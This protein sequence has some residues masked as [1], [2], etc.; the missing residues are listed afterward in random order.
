MKKS[1]LDMKERWKLVLGVLLLLS[2]VTSANAR[3]L[4]QQTPIQQTPMM[5][6]PSGKSITDSGL[7]AAGGYAAASTNVSVN[8]SVRPPSILARADYQKVYEQARALLTVGETFRQTELQLPPSCTTP[9]ECKLNYQNFNNGQLFFGF[10]SNYDEIDIRGYC[11]GDTPATWPIADTQIRG[12]LVRAREMYGFLALAEPA[13]VEVMVGGQ[14]ANVREIGRSGVLSAT[15]EIANIHMIF[16]NEFMVDAIDY[17][18]G[19]NDPRADQII[20]E[21]M[22]QLAMARQQFEQAVAVLTHAFNADFGGPNGGYIG[23][24]FGEREFDL[25]GI[26]SERMVLAISETAD[27][28]RQLGRDEEALTLYSEAFAN[29]YVQAMALATSADEQSENFLANGGT[30][31]INNIER[32]RDRSQAIHD[33]I[34][35][36]GFVDEYVPLQT[37]D[38]LRNL[39]RNDFLRDATEDEVRAENAQRE[40]DQNRTALAREMQNLS[41]TYDTRLLELCGPSQDNYRTCFGQG[42]VMRQNFHNRQAASKRIRQVDERMLNIERQIEIEQQRAQ[43]VIDFTLANGDVISATALAQGAINAQRT[44]TTTLESST[45]N[46]HA[47][48]E[49]RTIISGGIWPW[50]WDVKGEAIISAGYRHE[51]SWTDSTQTVWDPSA[52]ALAE[53]QGAQALQQAIIESEIIS[54]TSAATVK[55]MALQIS[56][57]LIEREILL[58][59]QN[60]LGAEQNDLVNQYNHLLNLRN[61][62][63]ADLV[64]SNLA[65]P[66]FRILRDQTTVEASRSIDVAAQFAYLTAKALEYE[67]LVRFPN[68]NDIFK[69]RTADGIDNFLIDLEAFRVAIGSPGERNRFPY[70]ISLARD[71]LGLSDDALDPDSVLSPN[72]RARLRFEG[73]QQLVE[74]SKVVNEN[75]QVIA[76]EIPFT[77]SLLDSRI[78]TPNIWNNRIA[79]VNLPLDVP[80]TEGISI[81]V[82][83]RQFGDIGTPEVQLTHGG[84][85]SYRT[86]TGEIVEYVPE[87]AK[88]S[89]YT[90]PQGFESKTKTATLLAGVNGNSRGT[91]SSALFNRSVAASNWT[92]RIDLNSPFNADLDF[93]QL[94]DIEINMDTTGIALANNL[95]AAQIDAAQLQAAFVRE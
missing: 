95:Q 41:L 21:E 17:R 87:N 28:L 46:I 51:W 20:A 69:I 71:L 80:G 36:M 32:L 22:E 81:N 82:L 31:I 60:R 91:P 92:L 88:L 48:A 43:Q 3:V 78:F 18:F 2:M 10:C 39:V 33:G 8:S 50:D 94:E 76:L 53:L 66:A 77:T 27:R 1:I 37:Y 42:G 5:T 49:H 56:E 62:A 34:N 89:G 29:Q 72:E 12:Q 45:D 63:R 73:F 15:R 90:V 13:D 70:R 44:T 26:V 68:L 58:E 47:G 4:L 24:Y 67:F 85:A 79:G 25:F 65:N 86:A 23:D 35:P 7:S 75:G 9:E 11:P 40:F 54:V 16:G 30:D 74:V 52:E 57:L 83:T 19:G 84:H 38:E 59:E 6:D 55:T 61:Q 64:D 14:P 93:S